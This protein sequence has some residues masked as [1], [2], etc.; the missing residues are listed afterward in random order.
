MELSASNIRNR[1]FSQGLRGLDENEVYAFLD[2]VADRWAEMAGRIETLE[3]KLNEIGDTANKVQATKKRA[4]ALQEELRTKEQRLDEREQ[5]LNERQGRLETKE[6]KLRSIADRLQDTLR[7][8]TQALSTLTEDGS[9][10]S[11]APADADD[12]TDG[13]STEEWVDSLFPNRLPGN[14]QA[15][16]PDQDEASSEEEAEED[17]SAS[18]SQFEAIKQD[19]QGMGEEREKATA[20]RNGEEEES[21]SPPTEEMNQIWDVFDEQE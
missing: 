18:E 9:S 5:E 3:A 7:E 6:A 14:E 1:S 21:D 16:T 11:D 4:E 19:V 13:K 17:L 8:E 2:E 15:K 10:S 20:S 12:D